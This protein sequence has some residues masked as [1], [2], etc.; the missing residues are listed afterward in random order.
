MAD[1]PINS[2]TMRPS[3]QKASKRQL[4]GISFPFRKENGEFPARDRDADCVQNDLFTL[5]KTVARSRVMRP[6]VGHTANDVVF[7]SKGGVLNARLQRIIRQTILNNE[8]R[9]DILQIRVSENDTTV[10]SGVQYLIK[11]VVDKVDL[12]EIQ[13]E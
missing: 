11:G 13:R 10:A 12:P 5:F 4:V 3:N 7:E 1:I 6:L 8:P 2:G 9:V